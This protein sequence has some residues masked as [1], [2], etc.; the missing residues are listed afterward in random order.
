[1]NITSKKTGGT[2]QGGT[3]TVSKAGM[4]S[5]TYQ[6]TTV[7]TYE[8]IPMD[9][10][11]INKMNINVYQIKNLPSKPLPAL[12]EKDIQMFII[13]KMLINA[14]KENVYYFPLGK[15]MYLHVE[16]N[17][18]RNKWYIKE[19][20]SAISDLNTTELHIIEKIEE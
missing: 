6:D 18:N 10:V 1:M 3:I 12:Q 19:T 8:K 11:D 4:N 9:I 20:I 13:I 14:S 2:Y 16:H 15:D 17:K 5:Y 7:H